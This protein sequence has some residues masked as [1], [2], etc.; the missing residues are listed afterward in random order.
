MAGKT[1]CDSV[2]SHLTR[3]YDPPHLHHNSSTGFS[4][5]PTLAQVSLS[6][7]PLSLHLHSSCSSFKI[8]IMPPT[9]K[10]AVPWTLD[11]IPHP[12]LHVL[13]ALLGSDNSTLS[14]HLSFTLITPNYQQ[15]A[16]C[17]LSLLL[18]LHY[19][20]GTPLRQRPFLLM[21]P[22]SL[23]NAAHRH[24]RLE[25]QLN[26]IPG[27]WNLLHNWE[28]AQRKSW[29][30]TSPRFLIVPSQ[31]LHTYLLDVSEVLRNLFCLQLHV[32][33]KSLCL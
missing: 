8:L 31:A 30:P 20:R 14:L 29:L 23:E 32:L 11:S 12:L 15:L 25:A 26:F 24:N 7:F 9:P 10:E 4:H 2:G 21:S 33:K 18:S 1:L 5:L 28:K 22:V 16:P 6:V 3:C 13:A 17:S 19:P 27:S